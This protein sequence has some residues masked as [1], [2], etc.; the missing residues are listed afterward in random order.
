MIRTI[1]HLQDHDKQDA[2]ATVEIYRA[3][4]YVFQ[5]PYRSNTDYLEAL[6]SHIKVSKA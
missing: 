1:F 4:I 6:K 5:S 3:S 2:M